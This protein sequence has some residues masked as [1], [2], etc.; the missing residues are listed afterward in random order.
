MPLNDNQRERYARHLTLQEIGE[1]GQEKLLQAKVLIIGAGGLGSPA[2]FYLAAAG[3][4]TIGLMDGDRV[5]LSN[6]QRQLL[7][8]TASIGEEKVTSAQARLG[9]LDPAIKLELY[10]CRLTA[11]NAQEILA[12]YEFVIDATDNFDSK[13]LI[14]RACHQAGKPYSHAGIRQF[15]G[16]TMTVHPGVSACYRCVFHEEGIPITTGTPSGPM[17]AIPGVIGSLQAIEAIKHT[18]SIGTPLT[19]TLLTFDALTMNTRKVPVRRD[20]FCP[21][22]GR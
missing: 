5:E 10:P 4:G 1:A 15:Y 3:I 13:F 9:A 8:T 7:H 20:P 16:Q 2:A 17:G 14:A 22:C 19:N 18:L 6:L 11:E 21:I 12:E